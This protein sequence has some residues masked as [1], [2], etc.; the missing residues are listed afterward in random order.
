MT[1]PPEATIEISTTS[2]QMSSYEEAGTPPKITMNGAPFAEL[3]APGLPTGFQ[4]VAIDSGADL[5]DPDNIL[6]NTYVFCQQDGGNWGGTYQYMYAQMINAFLN[7]GNYEQQLLLIASFGLDADMP[8]SND[9]LEFLLDRGA[10]PL[11]Q[12]WETTVDAG[13]QSSGWVGQPA[14]YVLIGS[15]GLAY[16]QGAEIYANGGGSANADISITIPNNVPPT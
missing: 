3:P 7:A 6:L 12:Q 5:T 9:G 4:L 14:S 1:V 10:G 16:G 15:S 13:S 8:P 2:Q 11:L